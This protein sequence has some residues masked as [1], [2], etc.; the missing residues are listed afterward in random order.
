MEIPKY[1]KENLK[2]LLGYAEAE[3]KKSFETG[4]NMAFYKAEEF[5]KD[6]I[7]SLETNLENYKKA[8]DSTRQEIADIA[9]FFKAHQSDN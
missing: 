2:T 6:K 3:D 4:A 8:Y 1:I 9:N 7:K 5:Y